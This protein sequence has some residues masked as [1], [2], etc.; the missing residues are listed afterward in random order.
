L[1]K[2]KN[3]GQKYQVGDGLS[4]PFYEDWRD[5]LKKSSVYYNNLTND[6]DNQEYADDNTTV[7]DGLTKMTD[8]NDNSTENYLENTVQKSSEN[9]EIS[10]MK[11]ENG[12]ETDSEIAEENFSEP[13]LKHPEIGQPQFGYQNNVIAFCFSQQGQS[14]IKRNAYCQDRCKLK[15][16][17]K[18]NILIMA[19]A[20]GV[21]SCELSDFGAQCAVESVVSYLCTEIY[22]RNIQNFDNK[23]AGELLRGAM[24]FAYS[25]VET[26]ADKLEQMVFSLQSTLT[27]A[28]YDYKDIYFGHAGDS[29]IV[30]LTTKGIYELATN[31]HKGEEA[32]SVFPLQSRTTWQFGKVENTVGFV[33]ATDGVLDHFVMNEAE[34]NRVFFP[35]IERIFKYEFN[36]LKGVEELCNWYYN[37]MKHSDFRAKVTDDIT[38]A[39]VA[40]Q[41]ALNIMAKK[42]IAP[43]FD[44]EE[45]DRK[46]KEYKQK[47]QKA[48][49]P[50]TK[51]ANA[52]TEKV[53][54]KLA[55]NKCNIPN[56]HTNSPNPVRVRCPRCGKLQPES[57]RCISCGLKI[58]DQD[59]SIFNKFKNKV[60][61]FFEDD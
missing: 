54:Q 46:T 12:R 47:I 24:S 30:V 16:V 19:I 15:F 42:G 5:N 2:E 56:D 57:K 39:A 21:G 60:F 11:Y 4:F 17:E 49:Y 25:E 35:F 10:D 58:K 18:S 9:D 26:L 7:Y 43:V 34:K 44:M 29:G 36:S 32:S 14:H 8:P 51:D 41:T 33:M 31:R 53:Q 6:N 61:G 23:T 3:K 1:C 22:K 37:E 52:T 38:F 28:L 13:K 40:N 50:D 55:G 48:L 20:D 27:V 45:W 59:T